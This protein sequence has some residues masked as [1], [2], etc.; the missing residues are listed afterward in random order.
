MKNLCRACSVDAAQTRNEVVRRSGCFEPANKSDPEAWRNNELSPSSF[1][2]RAREG[3]SQHR[4]LP[5]GLVQKESI[6]QVVHSCCAGLDVHKKSVY[7]VLMFGSD[8]RKQK[9]VRS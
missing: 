4:R 9:Q 2:W 7:C 5:S 6:M 3:D 8:G 1:G